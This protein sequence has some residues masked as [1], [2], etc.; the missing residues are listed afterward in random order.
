MKRT[1]RSFEKFPGHGRAAIVAFATLALLVMGYAQSCL[2]QQPSQKTF[3]S[4]AE[5]SSALYAAVQNHDEQAVIEIL[6]GEKDLV[7]A[8]DEAL[9]KLERERFVR[10][11]QEMHR[12]A[13]E[14]DG[15]TILYIGAENWPFPIPLVTKSG[16]WSFD[17]EA[18][19]QELLFRRIGENELTAIG[20]CHALVTAE[21]QHRA[22]SDSAIDGLL[23]NAR[24][25]RNPVPFN[26]YYF[27]ILAAQGKNAPG[28]VR[29]NIADHKMTGGFAFVAYA[30]EYRS[31]GVMTFIVDGAGR[32]YEK[33]LGPN[34]ATLAKAMT[35]YSPDSTWKPVD[36]EP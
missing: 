29:R 30:A 24:N 12:L 16:A 10:K 18:G 11:Y 34:T 4:A 14:P 20:A 6:G 35:S 21:K 31:S 17:S 8:D 33:D 32:V 2:A 5:A 15:T 22:K 19:R 9:D 28:G 27:R 3:S 25:D 23:A 13:R 7:S 1:T 26:G 36:I